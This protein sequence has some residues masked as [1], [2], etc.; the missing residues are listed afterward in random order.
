MF[1]S[2]PLGLMPEAVNLKY[3]YSYGN[4]DKPRQYRQPLCRV[5]GL[6]RPDR[7]NRFNV[8]VA[9]MKCQIS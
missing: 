2:K 1:S 4:R 8:R 9:V 3:L 5:I 6:T 7:F